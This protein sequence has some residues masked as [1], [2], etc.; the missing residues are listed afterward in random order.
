MTSDPRNVTNHL[1]DILL[2]TLF[3]LSQV[4]VNP[5]ICFRGKY[6]CT[7]LL[8]S[9]SEGLIVKVTEK[10]QHQK[11]FRYQSNGKNRPQSPWQREKLFAAAFSDLEQT[12]TVFL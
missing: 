4:L 2:Y 10:D 6:L 12:L 1:E 5:E 9:Q 8:L 11:S 3:F 7:T